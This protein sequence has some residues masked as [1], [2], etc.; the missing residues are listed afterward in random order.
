MKN[1]KRRSA[2]L[3]GLSLILMAIIAG[4]TYGY[5]HSVIYV[6]GNAAQSMTNLQLNKWLFISEFVGWTL[7]CLVD[8]IVVMALYVFLKGVNPKLSGLAAFLRL[9]YTAFLGYA[10]WQLGELL[11]LNDN[12]SAAQVN[13]QFEAF[14]SIWSMGLII[15]GA[16]L[17]TL[18]LLALK[19]P[20]ISKV[21]GWLLMLAGIS[22]L[23]IHLA[24]LLLEGQANTIA[25][26][27]VI[28]S[29]PMALG[30]LAF[31]VWLIT[32]GGKST[33]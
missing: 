11:P 25:E 4:F 23:G 16:H 33:Y 7:I 12:L 22:Y 1:Q 21:F 13:S 28:L 27:E 26:V 30:E 17:S 2:L 14:E 29:A 15:F 9:I 19:A 6:P 24:K 20:S 3:A 5:A 8:G 10:V 18:G 32:K 31:A